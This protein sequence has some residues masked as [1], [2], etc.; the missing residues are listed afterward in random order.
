[1]L[2]IMDAHTIVKFSLSLSY[3][4]YYKLYIAPQK[5][6]QHCDMILIRALIGFELNWAQSFLF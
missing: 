3:M 5:L 6:Y 1:M 2:Y 4:E